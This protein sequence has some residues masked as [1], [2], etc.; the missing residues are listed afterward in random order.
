[1]EQV[2]P[3]APLEPACALAPALGAELAAYA[4][5]W[6]EE[7]EAL[8]CAVDRAGT[9]WLRTWD[10]QGRR[11]DGV[12]WSGGRDRLL[13]RGYAA[14]VVSRALAGAGLGPF[15]ALGWITAY[16]DPGLYCPYT[17]SLATALALEKYGDPAWAAPLL[18]PFRDPASGWEG[19]TWMT[20]RAGG[21]DLGA[22]VETVAA[23]E[24][25]A[26]RLTGEKYFASNV[27]ADV[28][29]VAAR[30]AGAPPGVRG[31]GLFAVPRRRP[32]GG[33]NYRV[34]RLKDKIGTRSVAT[35]EVLLEG[36]VGWSLGGPG[37]GIYRILEVL[38][39]SRVA[40][41]VAAAALARRAL[42]EATAYARVRVVFGRPLA[43]HPLFA[44]EAR[45]MAAAVD[46]AVALAL[47]AAR[48]L[49][50]VWRVRPPYDDAYHRFRLLAHLAK[51]H[52]AEVAVA[53]ARWA[54]EAHG[55]LGML[56][57]QGV[58]RLLR[59]ALI[60]A[61]WEGTP[62]R[63]ALDGIEVCQRKGAHRLLAAHLA[64]RLRRGEA[65]RILRPVERLLAGAEPE[66][67]ARAV[68]AALARRVAAVLARGA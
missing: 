60:L 45:S 66:A 57:E 8:S 68:F 44:A 61:T 26:W 62:H 24:G 6:R 67:R 27:G 49:D 3:E 42:D 23:P 1:M 55:G 65:E 18:D 2:V 20:E 48:C 4:A 58:E 37:E 25:G 33:L 41:A 35:G 50:A 10:R 28:A 31:L 39:L 5:W 19:A 56:A 13:H 29:V 46:G 64:P 12:L 59:E 9:P 51:Y 47:E 40:N 14:G 17:V 54:M 63:Q 38:N 15:F 22:G 36:A 7:G 43:R 21:S 32:D 52:T 34:R 53:A 16:H 11:E 30:P